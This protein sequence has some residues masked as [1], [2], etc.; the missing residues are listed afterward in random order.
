ML[1]VTLGE[2]A[3]SVAGALNIAGIVALSPLFRPC[4][5]R[6]GA[7]D[8]LLARRLPGDE[9]VPDPR[10][11]TTRAITIQAPV[12][13][14]W[15]WL[16]QLGQRRGG[17][18]SYE[19][20]ENLAGCEIQNAERILPEYQD[21]AVG[22][23]LRLGPEGFP[24]FTVVEVIPD[25]ALVL[26][27]GPVPAEEEDAVEWS[28]AFILDRPDAGTTRLVARNRVDYDPTLANRIQWRGLIDPIAFVM[29]RKMLRT[30]KDL[31]EG[32]NHEK[33]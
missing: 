6:W 33:E 15:P 16:A 26:K 13:K 24:F 14:V 11:E 21:I 3:D 22:D 8:G 18:Y 12:E 31:A 28:W 25:R 20:L 2:T 9:Q 32:D 4:Y 5:R 7:T 1:D 19:Q 10:L 23:R 27:G 30:L 29:E 17:W